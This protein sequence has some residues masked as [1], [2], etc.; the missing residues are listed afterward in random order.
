M[1]VLSI[2]FPQGG[3]PHPGQQAWMLKASAAGKTTG[4]GVRDKETNCAE[5]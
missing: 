1:G 2:P 3:K 5:V 4:W